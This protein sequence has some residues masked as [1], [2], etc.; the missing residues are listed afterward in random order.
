[1][2][3]LENMTELERKHLENVNCP[4]FE[5]H[6]WVTGP[7]LNQRRVAIVST[8]G[9]HKREERPF[10][11]DSPVQYRIIPGDVRANDLIMTHVSANFD[12]TGFQQDW[13]TVFPIDRL[14]ELAEA[15]KI[16]SVAAYHYSFMGAFET[17]QLE[18]AARDVAGFLR[19]DN[20]DAVLLL[21]V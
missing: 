9:L 16:G 4:T 14:Q 7:A 2:A 1:M 19:K 17:A 5:T 11:L 10:T 13:N 21:P 18:P 15:G 6:P 3:R 8:A 20:V 12:P